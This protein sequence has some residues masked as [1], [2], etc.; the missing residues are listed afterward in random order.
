M[1][2]RFVRN[3]VFL[4]NL[5][6]EDSVLIF[7]N[8]LGLECLLSEKNLILSEIQIFGIGNGKIWE[9]T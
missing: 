2:F 7:A 1:R 5:Y 3:C 6:L 8:N 9:L 4:S